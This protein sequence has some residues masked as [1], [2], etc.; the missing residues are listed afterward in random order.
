MEI[1]LAV[2]ASKPLLYVI[3]TFSAEAYLG[4]CKTSTMELFCE[5]NYDQKLLPTVVKKTP[6]Y[7]FEVF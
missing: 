1:I 7:F 3:S 5:N 2:L 6:S 4:L